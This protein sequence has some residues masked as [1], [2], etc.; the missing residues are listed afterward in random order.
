M[1]ALQVPLTARME[2]RRTPLLPIELVELIV[3]CLPLE[4]RFYVAVHLRLLSVRNACIPLLP[5]ASMDCASY[6][7]QVDL[8]TWWKNSSL[9][10]KWSSFAINWA[11]ERGHVHVLEW[12]KNS[13]LQCRWTEQA[14]DWALHEGRVHVL[15]WWKNSG[16]ECKY[17]ASHVM[18]IASSQGHVEVLEW[19]KN[20]GFECQWS[21][22]KN[23]IRNRSFKGAMDVQ[24]CDSAPV[25][26]PLASSSSFCAIFCFARELTIDK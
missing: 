1:K 19:W 4:Q 23:I 25:L 16:L 17:Q 5:Y 9:E 7:G 2:D 15:E 26:C 21:G 22:W 13:G 11:S 12:W 3:L 14:M 8:L 10:C 6:K 20:S 18:N 24:R